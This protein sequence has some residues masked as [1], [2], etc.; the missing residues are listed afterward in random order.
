MSKSPA[1][2][3]ASFAQTRVRFVQFS[4]SPAR[5]PVRAEQVRARTA[6][7]SLRLTQSPL[8]LLAAR[9]RKLRTCPL[10]VRA[11]YTFKNRQYRLSET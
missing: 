9:A 3:Q 11:I 7:T 4:L 8:S 10:K 5:L 2:M 1:Q 6:Q